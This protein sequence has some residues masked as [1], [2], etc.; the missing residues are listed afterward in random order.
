M[1]RRNR[2]LHGNSPDK[3]RIALLLIDVINDLE[4]PEGDQI[5]PH[6]L[7][8][9]RQIHALKQR[10]RESKIPTIYVN[11]NFGRWRSDQCPGGTLS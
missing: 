3:S 10:A 4:F 5:L 1:T 2:S 6:A 8:M 11:E 7:A 9:A